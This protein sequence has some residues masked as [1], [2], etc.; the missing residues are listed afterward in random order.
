M[1]DTQLKISALLCNDSLL[2][3]V[4]QIYLEITIKNRGK[5]RRME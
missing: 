3:T 1:I 5:L 2:Y 4:T